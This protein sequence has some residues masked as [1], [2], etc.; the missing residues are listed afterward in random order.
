MHFHTVA[1]LTGATAAV[2]TTTTS[3]FLPGYQGRELHAS[4]IGSVRVK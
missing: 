2:A 3:L 4:V 1:I